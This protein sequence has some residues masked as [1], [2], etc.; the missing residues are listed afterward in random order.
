MDQNSHATQD[1]TQYRDYYQSLSYPMSIYEIARIFAPGGHV[2]DGKYDDIEDYRTNQQ[3]QWPELDTEFYFH[4]PPNLFALTSKFFE[5]TGAY[6]LA[7]TNHWLDGENFREWEKKVDFLAKRWR[8]LLVD[9]LNEEALEIIL[10]M[11]PRANFRLPTSCREGADQGPPDRAQLLDS[12]LENLDELWETWTGSK[13]KQARNWTLFFEW[14]RLRAEFVERTKQFNILSRARTYAG[15]EGAESKDKP[16][17]KELCDDWKLV[18]DNIE[19]PRTAN[20]LDIWRTDK[21]GLRL[22]KALWTI[23]SLA[24]KACVGWGIRSYLTDDEQEWTPDKQEKKRRFDRLVTRLLEKSGNLS[25][26]SNDRGRVLPKRHTPE[27]GATLRSSSTYLSYHSSSTDVRW[28]TKAAGIVKNRSG[29]RPSGR[30]AVSAAPHDRIIDEHVNILLLPWPK[31]ISARDFWT[32]SQSEAEVGG[33][34]DRVFCYRPRQDDPLSETGYL[35]KD[36]KR[37]L[38]AAKKEVEE[39]DLVVLP[40]CAIDEGLFANRQFLDVLT[41]SKIKAVIAGT[42]GWKGDEDSGIGKNQL[43]FAFREEDDDGRLKDELSI[44][45][46]HKQHRWKLDKW[47]IVSYDLGSRLHPSANHWEHIELGRREAMF[48]NLG[49]EIT[50]C[51]IICE[52]LARQESLAELIRSVGPS[53]VVTLLMDGPQRQDRWS[54][55]YAQFFSDDP[56]CAT[57]TLTSRGLFDRWNNNRPSTW[58]SNKIALWCERGGRPQEI[59][60]EADSEAVVLC[61]APELV[62]SSTIDGRS[63]QITT[64]SLTYGGVIQV[65]AVK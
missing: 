38:G 30:A 49:Q 52:D 25:F 18:H 54:A 34:R 47:Q 6:G 65:P 27:V 7:A 12:K 62:E 50:I 51:P 40:E 24:D 16:Y 23:H 42:Y 8:S 20:C 60:L 19:T 11:I 43:C 59:P 14:A 53:L 48:I 5:A 41:K 2:V 9:N 39:V 64:C 10:P 31:K 55:R 46:Y 35:V 57:L 15:S 58:Q 4:W 56:G 37:V 13:R 45:W 22:F 44:E 29:H 17:F 61:L 36:L 33:A 32:S 63:D 3:K 21:D 1:E 26:I 28:I